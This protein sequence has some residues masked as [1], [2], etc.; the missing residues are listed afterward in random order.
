MKLRGDRGGS[1]E[2][3]PA[4][5]IVSRGSPLLTM[6]R[7]AAFLSSPYAGVRIVPLRSECTPV[8][9]IFD[10]LPWESSK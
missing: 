4:Q 2:K 3:L 8:N 7:L 5:T 1:N 10:N 9:Q 6:P